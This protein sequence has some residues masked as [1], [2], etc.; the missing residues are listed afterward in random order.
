MPNVAKNLNLK[1]VFNK[2]NEKNWFFNYL[3]EQFRISD[4]KI[5]GT[6]AIII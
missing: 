6:L 3:L 5:V 4:R 1:L 2:I